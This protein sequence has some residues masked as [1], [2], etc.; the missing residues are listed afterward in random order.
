MIEV[1]DAPGSGNGYK[2]RLLLTLLGV[3]HRTHWLN[4]LKGES[5]TRDFLAVNPNGK[6]PA[7]VLPDGTC[8]AESN[9]L[10]YH[11]AQGTRFWPDA[12]V[13]RTRVLQW[14]FFEQYSH[15]PAL[16]VL[17]FWLHF[18]TMTPDREAQIPLK[19]SQSFHALGVMETRL[20]DHAW[21]AGEAPSI[22]DLALYA[23]THVAH[24]ADVSLEAFPGIR[25]WIK[26][27]EALPGWVSMMDGVPFEMSAADLRPAG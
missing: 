23:Y 22:A 13:D 20:K 17:R 26:A 19:R 6:I 27:I 7:V 10:L 2:L 8:L 21:L 3:E 25:A 18:L 1:Y 14:M 24:E 15:E 16:A 9:A 4:I 11:F 12:P 5:R